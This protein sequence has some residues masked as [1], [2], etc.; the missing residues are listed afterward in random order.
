MSTRLAS[1]YSPRPGWLD[2]AVCKDYPQEWWYGGPDGKP[3][4][5]RLLAKAKALCGECPVVRE[6]LVTALYRNEPYGVWGGYTRVER[7]RA[8]RRNNGSITMALAD[9]DADA[10]V[11]YPD[12]GEH[13]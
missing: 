1:H 10:F 4:S 13:G 9:H 6:C 11:D 7:V 12:G 3:Q 2:D 5:A 8:L